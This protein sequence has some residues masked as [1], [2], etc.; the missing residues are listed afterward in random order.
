MSACCFTV[1]AKSDTAL[2]FG[3]GSVIEDKADSGRGL[4]G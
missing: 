1:W 4:R 3:Q 2:Y